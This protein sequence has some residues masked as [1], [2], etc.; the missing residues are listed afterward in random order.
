[1][2]KELIHKLDELRDLLNDTVVYKQAAWDKKDEGSW[3]R[4]WA[5]MDNLEDSQKAI[6][7]FKLK[8]T[9][10]IL[11]RYGI[12]QSLYVQQDAL[13]DLASALGL[14]GISYKNHKRLQ[15]IRNVRDETIGHP[16]YREKAGKGEYKDGS[17]SFTSMYFENTKKQLTY[18][19]YTAKGSEHKTIDLTKVVEDQEVL[20]AIEIEKVIKQIKKRETNHKELFQGKKISQ[21]LPSFNY[22]IQKMYPFEKTRKISRMNFLIIKNE[23]KKFETEYIKRYGE[24]SLTKDYIRNP[25]T[26]ECILK[27]HK[28]FD[29]IE[30][31]IDLSDNVLEIDLEVYVEALARELAGLKEMALEI[32]EEF[33]LNKKP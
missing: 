11:D 24:N 29:R 3:S 17:L 2:K 25:G 30:E 6:E 14:K 13:L 20:L 4:L 18:M 7:L 8:T 22:E 9:I 5:S 33:N 32:D 16:T 19:V 1:M 28:L 21:I 15:E 12:L 26:V 23:V 31:M 27:I 10:S